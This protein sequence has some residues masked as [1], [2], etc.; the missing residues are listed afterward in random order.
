M[1]KNH[2]YIYMIENRANLREYLCRMWNPAEHN[3]RGT[4]HMKFLSSAEILPVADRRVYRLS[5]YIEGLPPRAPA[6][7]H[8]TSDGDRWNIVENLFLMMQ[9]DLFTLALGLRVVLFGER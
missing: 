9:L 8:S 3:E 4:I 2:V 7:G 5:R 1:I 6:R